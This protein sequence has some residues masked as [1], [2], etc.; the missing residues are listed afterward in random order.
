MRLFFTLLLLATAACASAQTTP[1]PIEI[2]CHADHRIAMSFAIAALRTPATT[3]DDPGC[4]KK[5]FPGF[6]AFLADLRHDWS[7]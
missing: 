7:L 3:F 5:T 2:A 4:V 6:H 1:K